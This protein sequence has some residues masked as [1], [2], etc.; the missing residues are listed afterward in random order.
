MGILDHLR[1]S[2]IT[3]HDTTNISHQEFYLGQQINGFFVTNINITTDMLV[4]VT[5]SCTGEEE[6]KTKA[7]VIHGYKFEAITEEG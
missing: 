4:V 2:R 6:T 3:F 7:H 1:I 5:L